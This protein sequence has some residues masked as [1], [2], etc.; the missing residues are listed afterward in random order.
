MQIPLI[1]QQA[2]QE[3]MELHCR[4]EE[5]IGILQDDN[6]LISFYDG[7][8]KVRNE[9]AYYEKRN[10]KFIGQM[11]YFTRQRPE[12]KQQ[13]QVQDKSVLEFIVNWISI[14][15]ILISICFVIFY[16]MPLINKIVD[17]LLLAYQE[18]NY[19]L[20]DKSIVLNISIGFLIVLLFAG[21]NYVGVLLYLIINCVGLNCFGLYCFELDCVGLGCVGVKLYFVELF[22][23]LLG[24]RCDVLS[25]DVLD[26]DG[27][28]CDLL[29]CVGL[30]CSEFFAMYMCNIKK[31]AWKKEYVDIMILGH[32]GGDKF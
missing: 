17:N 26:C 5:Q 11:E 3:R 15:L 4:K 16:G 31:R 32:I 14:L 28:S 1:R 27:L 13:E 20:I 19:Y 29:S 10:M 12:M 23:I 9:L 22:W 18:Y 7:A 6:S 8:A 24:F 30:D 25:Y 21:L 2:L